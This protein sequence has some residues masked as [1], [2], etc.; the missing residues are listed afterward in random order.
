MN[1][2]GEPGIGEQ[3][4]VPVRGQGRLSPVCGPRLGSQGAAAIW[5]MA[6]GAGVGGTAYSVTRLGKRLEMRLPDKSP[7]ACHRGRCTLVGCCICPGPLPV[8]NCQG[9]GGTVRRLAAAST[10]T[11]RLLPA[12]RGQGY[13]SSI[14][15]CVCLDTPLV[16]SCQGSGRLVWHVDSAA[17]PVNRGYSWSVAGPLGDTPRSGRVERRTQ[18]RHG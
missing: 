10:L 11:R 12:V 16:A 13:C 15:C 6:A 14:G 4:P 8:A 9:S 3:C 18:A 17:P 7:T 2:R 1:Q 5:G